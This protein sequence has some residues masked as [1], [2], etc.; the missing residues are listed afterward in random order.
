MSFSVD[1]V[2]LSTRCLLTLNRELIFEGKRCLFDLGISGRGS[3]SVVS[4][5]TTASPFA[6]AQRTELKATR[7]PTSLLR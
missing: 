2:L 3:A 4:N 7:N 5:A 6:N 1:V